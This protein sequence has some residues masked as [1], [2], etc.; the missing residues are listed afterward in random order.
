M[1]QCFA[2]RADFQQRVPIEA[3]GRLTADG[4]GGGPLFAGGHLVTNGSR[5]AV[6]LGPM[7]KILATSEIVLLGGL[8][9]VAGR[10]RALP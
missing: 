8:W 4:R 3:R 6:G 7:V 9:Q 10:R 2:V 1:D 5:R